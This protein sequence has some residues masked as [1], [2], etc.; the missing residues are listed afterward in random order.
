MAKTE[1]KCKKVSIVNMGC[2]VNQYECDTIA[3]L[4]CASGFDVDFGLVVADIYFVNTCAVTNEGERK[5]RNVITKLLKLNP[6]ASVYVAGCASENNS[7]HFS[8]IANVK[9]VIGTTGKNS[10]AQKICDDYGKKLVY[11][12]MHISNRTRGVLKCQ[13]GCNNFC[14]YCLIPYVRGREKSRPLDELNNEII[15]MH[16]SGVHEVVLTGIN[17]SSYGNDFGD[18]TTLLDVAKIFSKN[19]FDM[20]YRFSSL[21]VNIITKEFLEYLS[22]DKH[23]CPHFHLSM[24]SGCNKTLKDMNR[25]YTKEEY[26]SKV[27]LIRKYFPLAAITTDVIVGFPTETEQDFA[28]TVETCKNANFFEMHVFPYSKREG[29]VAAKFKNVA[30]NVKD[31][32]WTLKNL[33]AENHDKF[34]KRNIKEDKIKEIIIETTDGEYYTAHTNNYIKVYVSKNDCKDLKN[35]DKCLAVLQELYLD[36]AKATIYQH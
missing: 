32:V 22:S 11:S 25:H 35:N 3:G 5:S 8:K 23:F 18:G 16:N 17:L 24:Q 14:T 28:E 12:N 27:A 13:D 33:A 6:K 2:K 1:E 26:L 20:R 10:I 21:E 15:S 7:E 31:R 36:G 30:T 29:T 34:I 4:L 9:Y 19:N